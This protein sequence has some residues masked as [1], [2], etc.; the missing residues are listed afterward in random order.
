MVLHAQG[1][2]VG[3][4]SRFLDAARDA[5]PSDAPKD[6][7]SRFFYLR[8]AVRASMGDTAGAQQRPRGRGV[9]LAQG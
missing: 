5:M 6:D 9:G 3:A 8:G 2:S 4:V 1:Y 7:V